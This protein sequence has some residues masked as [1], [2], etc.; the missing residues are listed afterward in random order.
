MG[1]G[2]GPELESARASWPGRAAMGCN[3]A[4]G[5]ARAKVGSEA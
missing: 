1:A 2:G 4:T 5:Q 3:S